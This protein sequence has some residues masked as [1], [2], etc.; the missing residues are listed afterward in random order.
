MVRRG[1]LD[2]Y[3]DQPVSAHP[4]KLVSDYAINQKLALQWGVRSVLA[5]VPIK[6]L[7]KIAPLRIWVFFRQPDSHCQ[8]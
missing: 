1:F 5:R 7:Y 8:K 2:I 6:E 3:P 4:Q